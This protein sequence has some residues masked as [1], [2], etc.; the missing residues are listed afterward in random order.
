[1]HSPSE[2][3]GKTKNMVGDYKI[4]SEVIGVGSYAIVRHAYNT[5]TSQQVAVKI[6]DL[7]HPQIRDRAF[8]EAEVLREVGRHKNIIALYDFHEDDRHLYLFMEYA[9][10]GD[11][12]SHVH[13][14]GTLSEGKARYFFK[15]CVDALGYCHERRVAHHDIKLENMLLTTEQ[16]LRLSDFGLSQKLHA[17]EGGITS[18]GGSP[19]YM[20]PEVFS[21]QPHN[22]QVDVWSLGICLYVMVSGTFPFVANNYTDLEE[23]V[24]FDDVPSIYGISEHLNDLIQGMLR[25]DPLKRLSLAIIR[26]HRWVVEKGRY[27]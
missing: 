10:G 15:Q 7:T 19:L 22:E 4:G 27:L 26:Q 18:Y 14:L 6:I 11:L 9:S 21:L 5:R 8:R 1:M 16:S 2:E 25:K 17:M 12:F 23:K 24:L 3:A 13:R 20:A